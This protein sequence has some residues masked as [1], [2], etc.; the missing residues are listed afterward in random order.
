MWE[1]ELPGHTRVLAQ[2]GLGGLAFDE[3]ARSLEILASDALPVVRREIARLTARAPTARGLLS[4]VRRL[5][6]MSSDRRRCDEEG[7]G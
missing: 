1:R 6:S 7:T 2:I 4:A 5:A 3:T